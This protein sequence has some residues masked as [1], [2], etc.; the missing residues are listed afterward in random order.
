[1]I[2]ID[3]L[4]IGLVPVPADARGIVIAEGET[5]AHFHRVSAK[6]K[7][8][9]VL[10]QFKDARHTDRVLEVKSKGTVSVIGGGSKEAPRHAA[11]TIAPGFYRARIQKKNDAGRVR[12]V[13]D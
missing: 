4:P 13:V 2:E 1:L 9:V 8:D 7:G 10:H 11:F 12:A 5:S 6:K 3:A